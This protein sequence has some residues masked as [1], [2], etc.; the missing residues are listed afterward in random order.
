[1]NEA[2][3]VA[4]PPRT[5]YFFGSLGWTLLAYVAYAFGGLLALLAMAVVKQVHLSASPEAVSALADQGYWRPAISLSVFPLVL[6]VIWIAIRLARRQFVEY[7]ALTWPRKDELVFALAV[8]FVVIQFLS[9][10]GSIANTATD[11][12]TVDMYQSARDRGHLFL[13]LATTCLGAPIA[14]EFVV[15]GFLFRGWSESFLG[16]LGAIVLGSALWLQ[17]IHS[18][19]G[20]AGSISS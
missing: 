8:L 16:P 5:W 10:I 1:M 13:F 9:A 14:E 6:G 2:V 17:P 15:R 12:F 7:L 19:I 4:K 20:S 18:M 3:R 11:T